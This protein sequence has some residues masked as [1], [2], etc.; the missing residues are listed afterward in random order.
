MLPSLVVRPIA[1]VVL[2]VYLYAA[3]VLVLLLLLL[4]LLLLGLFLWRLESR[5]VLP[6]ESVWLLDDGT[7]GV[8]GPSGLQV[9]FV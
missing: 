5:D 2:E 8:L 6:L 3:V 7:P 9:Q 1:T 4:L